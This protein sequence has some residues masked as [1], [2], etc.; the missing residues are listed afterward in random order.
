[1]VN[2]EVDR[3]PPGKWFLEFFA[4][5]I[6]KHRIKDVFSTAALTELGLFFFINGMPAAR[7]EFRSGC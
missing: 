3:R 7:A 4:A 2:K 6:T 1:M 5:F